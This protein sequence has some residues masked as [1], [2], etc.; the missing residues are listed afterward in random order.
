M[1]LIFLGCFFKPPINDHLA[2]KLLWVL[3]FALLIVGCAS[4]KEFDVE[5]SSLKNAKVTFGTFESQKVTEFYN[6]KTSRDS[7]ILVSPKDNR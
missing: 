5:N 4:Q 3:V 1:Y 6:V 2:M 7:L